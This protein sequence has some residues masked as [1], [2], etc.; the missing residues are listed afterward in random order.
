VK[1]S[2]ICHFTVHPRRMP[3]SHDH[4]ANDIITTGD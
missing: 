1:D 4:P 3:P 2:S